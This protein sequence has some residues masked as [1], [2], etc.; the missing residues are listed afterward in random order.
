MIPGKAVPG[1]AC[2]GLTAEFLMVLAALETVSLLLGKAAVLQA[3]VPKSIQPAAITAADRYTN[4][5]F[6]LL[7]FDCSAKV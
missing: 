3:A 1:V 6:I 4:S 7:F 2:A 5:F